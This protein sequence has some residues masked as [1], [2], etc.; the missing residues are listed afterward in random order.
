MTTQVFEWS[1]GE[2][3]VRADVDQSAHEVKFRFPPESFLGFFRK[4]FQSNARL[5]KVEEATEGTGYHIFT[6][7]INQH[8]EKRWRDAVEQVGNL[9]GSHKFFRSMAKEPA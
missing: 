3:A 6:L 7:T 9:L 1:K 5:W 2:S 4:Y 8:W